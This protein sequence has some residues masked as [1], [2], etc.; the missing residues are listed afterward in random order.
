MA[1]AVANEF[2]TDWGIG[3]TGQLGRRDPLNP[4]V[5]TNQVFYSFFN[6]NRNKFYNYRIELEESDRFSKKYDVVKDIVKNFELILRGG[7]Q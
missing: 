2:G 1:R 5:K 6:S 7:S 3:V 4:G